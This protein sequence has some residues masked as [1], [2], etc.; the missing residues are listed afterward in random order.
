M[1]SHGPLIFGCVTTHTQLDI[2][3]GASLDYSLDHPGE[4]LRVTADTVTGDYTGRVTV[5]EGAEFVMNEDDV[6][7]PFAIRAMADTHVRLPQHSFDC[8]NIDLS[9]AGAAFVLFW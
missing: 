9:F 2:R 6:L 5:R 4:Q 3:G 1:T 8:K 7:M